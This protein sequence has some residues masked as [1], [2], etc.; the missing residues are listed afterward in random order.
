[1]TSRCFSGSMAVLGLLVL[2]AAQG[3]D[4]P[5]GPQRINVQQ[6]G[7]PQEPANLERRVTEL[8]VQMKELSEAVKKLQT[9]L[10]AGKGNQDKAEVNLFSLKHAKSDSVAQVLRDLFPEKDGVHLRIASDAALN[11]VV[12]RGSRQELEVVEAIVGRMETIAEQKRGQNAA[13]PQTRK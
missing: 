5:A 4:L 8:E 9:E 3:Q 6:K 1:M 11:T 7:S 10:K 13:P 2:G 12:V